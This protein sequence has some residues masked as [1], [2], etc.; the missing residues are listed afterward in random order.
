M[1]TQVESNQ[2]LRLFVTV[3]R[4]FPIWI[5][6]H[7]GIGWKFYNSPR[8]KL[9]PIDSWW[10]GDLW[11]EWNRGIRENPST[12]SSLDFIACLNLPIPNGWA[13]RSYECIS[14]PPNRLRFS[15]NV[16]ECIRN[17]LWSSTIFQIGEFVA[18]VL[19]SSK[20][21]SRIPDRHTIGKNWLRT[22]QFS[23]D[24]HELSTFQPR[25]QISVVLWLFVGWWACVKYAPMT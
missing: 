14:T 12:I 19:N 24:L 8:I 4:L 22:V 3:S 18:K 16:Q 6:K 17:V 15:C 21:L 10:F 7:H 1:A 23:K 5:V 25:I 2:I 13:K 9:N 11:S 20:L